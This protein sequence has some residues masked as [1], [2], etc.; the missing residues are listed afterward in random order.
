MDEIDGQLLNPLTMRDKDA[1][2]IMAVR[3]EVMPEC[4]IGNPTGDLCAIDHHRKPD[5]PFALIIG[6]TREA[7]Y[8]HDPIPFPMM[9]SCILHV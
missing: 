9:A 6:F 3:T 7:C 8:L 5:H 2:R 1:H 4:L